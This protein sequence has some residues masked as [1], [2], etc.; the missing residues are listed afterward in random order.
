MGEV[1]RAKD[2]TLDRH[3]AIKVMPESFALDA[4]RIARFTREAKTLAALNHPNIAAI[5]GFEKT[6]DLT[7]LVMEL[8]EGEELSVIIARGPIPLLDA[9]PIARQIAEALEAAHEQGII[10]RDLKP[11][12]IKVRADGTVKVLDFGLAKAIDPAGASSADPMHSPT[13]TARATQMGMI[14]GTAAYMAPEQARGKTVDKRTDIWAFGVVFYEMLTGTRA[15]P[16]VD[17]TDTLA[18]VVRGEPD[19]SLVPNGISPALLVF[20]RRCVE[21]DPKQRIGDI[22]DVRLALDGAFETPAAQTSAPA[23][24]ATRRGRVAWMAFGAAVLGMTAFAV[25]AVRHLQETS[26]PE[27]R[28]DIVTPGT[29]TPTSFALSPDGRQLVFTASSD[30][31]SRLWLRNLASA[32]AQPLSGTEG[33]SLPFWSPDGRSL[34]FFADD[35]LKRLDLGGGAPQA[36]APVIAGRGGTWN[37]EGVILFAPNTQG[38]LFRIAALGG[39]VVEVAGRNAHANFRHPSFLPDGRQFVF[40]EYGA[41]NTSGIYLGSLDSGETTQLTTGGSRG[42]YVAPGW[43]LWLR[44]QT[45]VAQRLNLGRK[46][47]IGDPI[48]VADPVGVDPGGAIAVSVSAEGLVA[49]RAGLADA[50]QYTWLDRAGK[51]V[52][53]AGAPDMDAPNGPELSADGRWLALDR[54][55]QGNRDVWLM[56]LVRDGLT[57]FTF[58]AALDGYSV[59]SPDGARLVFESKRKAGSWDL[60]IKPSSGAGTEEV[61]LETPNDEWP[62]DWSRDGRFLLYH[63]TDPK[64][65]PDLWAL[66]MTGADRKPL[67]VANTPFTENNGQFSPDGRLVAYETN[68]SGRFEIVVQT[69]PERRG[70]WQPSTAGGRQPRWRADGKELY[71]VAP[72][73]TMMAVTVAA[74]GAELEAGKAVALFSTNIPWG[75]DKAQYAVAR[76]G[77]FLINQTREGTATPPITLIQHWNPEAKK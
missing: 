16:G 25:P 60:W 35:K 76:D 67:V 34:G 36:L 61:L 70:K 48:T 13:L 53:V 15:F 65:G 57:R 45:L 40:L 3:V 30:G 24:L 55:V 7:A 31:V 54:T 37:A 43:L 75:S 66:P 47:L 9:L 38:P 10:H 33:A 27:T 29:P 58:D 52:G 14:L 59:W 72:D 26:P 50:R 18:A 71:F 44:G 5:F 11:A 21:K 17:I 6:P 77:R 63:V 42:L 2:T 41:T 39:Q 56:D 4:D 69:F 1:Y 68:E 12:N 64:T 62:Y 23:V 49:Y 19:W 46:A 32:T 22:H 20:L 8:V 51:A 74:S 73:S 28:V